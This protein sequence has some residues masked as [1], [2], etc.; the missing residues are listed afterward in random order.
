MTNHTNPNCPSFH[1]HLDM[2]R[3]LDTYEA[4][5]ELELVE[6]AE[7]RWAPCTGTHTDHLPL[8]DPP[9]HADHNEPCAW[10]GA[11]WVK[12]PEGHDVMDHKV[13]CDF[14]GATS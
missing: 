5:T 14:M 9:H 13:G 1:D 2:V 11:R 4:R 12:A 8:E 7:A 3:R 6:A 10:C